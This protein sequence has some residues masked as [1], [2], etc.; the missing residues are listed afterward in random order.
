MAVSARLK[1]FVRGRLKAESPPDFDPEFTELFGFVQ[2]FT[3]TSKERVYALR[4]SVQ[5]VLTHGIPGDIVECGVWKG[6]A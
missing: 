3:M 1:Q 2:P 4:E 6:E 5:Y